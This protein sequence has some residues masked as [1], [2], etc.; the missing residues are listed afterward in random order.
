MKK[1]R[2][3]AIVV[4]LGTLA[5]ATSHNKPA[6]PHANCCLCMCHS[7]DETKCSRMC[8]RLQHSKAVV[9]EPAMNKCTVSCKRAGVKQVPEENTEKETNQGK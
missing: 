8:I 5:F 2:I 6:E 3:L 7:V 9:E 4:L 1:T